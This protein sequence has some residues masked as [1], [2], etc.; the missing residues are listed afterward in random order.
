MLPI[1]IAGIG[2][3]VGALILNWTMPKNKSHQQHQVWIA[4]GAAAGAVGALMFMV[5]LNFCTF[6]SDNKLPEIQLG[7]GILLIILGIVI[8]TGIAWAFA[9]GRFTTVE[10]TPGTFPYQ[11]FLPWLLLTP[12]LIILIL[13]LYYPF[14]DTLRLSTLLIGRGNKSAEICLQNFATLPSDASYVAGVARTF[15]FTGLIVV[16]GLTISLGIA[17]MAF[18][19]VKGASIY[20][21]LLI[22]P[23]A[24]SPAIAGIIF[25]LMFNPQ[26]GLINYFTQTLFGIRV[27]WLNSPILASGLVV[28]A[29]IW[30][31]LGFNILFYIAGLQS[32]PRDLQE[33]AA[34]DGANSLQRFWYVTL[35]LLSPITFFLVVTNIT[36]AFFEMFGT[37]DYLTEG[38]PLESTTVMIYNVFKLQRQTVGLGKAGAQSIV[39]FLLVVGITY[40]QFRTSERRVNYGS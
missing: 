11:R 5:P 24:I 25:R 37:I 36:F 33:A 32:I 2:A 38:G 15:V 3:L 40:W 26:G 10:N 7:L 21:T 8:T 35:P 17:I 18:Q 12:T 39:L 20:R 22:W 29:S 27:D 23:Y 34:I 19:P 28:A 16:L 14:L 1:I 6:N 30:T 13:F 31:R 4:V 9:T